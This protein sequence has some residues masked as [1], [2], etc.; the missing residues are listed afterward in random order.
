[1]AKGSKCHPVQGPRS[2]PKKHCIN[3][4]TNG[5]EERRRSLIEAWSLEL[6]AA[7]ELEVEVILSTEELEV[8]L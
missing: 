7:L 2:A 6:E 4:L 1:V 8:S 5:E 3:A